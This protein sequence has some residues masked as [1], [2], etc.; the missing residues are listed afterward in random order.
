MSHDGCCPPHLAVARPRECST[1]CELIRLVA[2]DAAIGL[3]DRRRRAVPRIVTAVTSNA[4]QP[5]RTTE[6]D[7]QTPFK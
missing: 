2:G 3:T 5:L 6:L 7:R 1:E 4:K